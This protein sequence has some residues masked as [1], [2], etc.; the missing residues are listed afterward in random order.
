MANATGS[1]EAAMATS[2]RRACSRPR[3]RG[4]CS[5]KKRRSASTRRVFPR[6]AA[7]RWLAAFGSRQ[8]RVS[9][10]QFVR[11]TPLT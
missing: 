7:K 5:R 3:F 6:P 10:L 1:D 9:D 11:M 2:A 8:K 4:L